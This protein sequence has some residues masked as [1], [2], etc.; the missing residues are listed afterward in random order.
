MS[1]KNSH[2]STVPVTD[3]ESGSCDAPLAKK[4]TSGYAPRA[5]LHIHSYRKRLTDP[6]GVSAKAVIDGIVKAGLL[7]DDSTEYIAQVSY[8]Q[9]K[10]T[11]EK[12]IIT[13]TFLP[14]KP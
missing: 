5:C 7:P 8:G 9:E 14:E 11:E 1:A 6:D 10:A 2:N 13:V 3:L 12:T 4:E